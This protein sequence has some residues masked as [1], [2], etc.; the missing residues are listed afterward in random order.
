MRIFRPEKKLGCYVL[1]LL[2]SLCPTLL[3]A[4]QT[5]TGKVVDAKTKEAIIGAVIK[6]KDSTQGTVTDVNGQFKIQAGNGGILIISYVGYLSQQ[7]TIN[8]PTANVSLETDAKNLSDVV[9][10]GYGTQKRSDLTGAVASVSTE[11]LTK[12]A[13]SSAIGSMQGIVPGANIIRN[14]NKPGGGFTVDIRG[15]HSITGSNAPL[16][17]IDGVPGADL[18]KINP[19]DIEK[20]DVLKDAS[21][22][23]IYGSRGANGV[24]IV[25]TKRGQTGKPKI[26]YNGYYGVRN[27]TNKPQMMNVDEF[28]QLAREAA[29]AT[30]NNVYKPDDQVFTDPSELQ[31]VKT[32]QGFDWINAVSNPAPQTSHTLSATGGNEEIRYT[33]SGGYYYEKGMLYPQSYTR[34]NLRASLDIKATQA[35]SFGGS[36]YF[37]NEKRALGNNDLLQDMFRLRPTQFPNSLVTGA[38]AFQYSSNGLFN[39]L[40]TSQNVFNDVK[41]NNLLGNI[42]VALRPVKGLEIK[43]TFSPYFTNA[44][45]GNYT[46]VFSKALQGTAAGATASYAKANVGNWVFDN[47]INYKW[48]KDIHQLEVTGVYSLQR[49]QSDNLNAAS[50]DLT[51][52]S[53]YYNLQG[54]TMT[55]F[56]SSYT[57]SQLAS[58]LGR[59]NYTLNSKYLLTASARYDGSSKLAAGHKWVLFPSA[60]LAWRASEE[61]FLK[62][63][64]WLDNLKVRLGYGVIGNDSV[65][66]YQSTQ[67]IS[68]PTYYSFG[69]DVIGNSPGNLPNPNLSWEKTYEVNLGLDFGIFKN[70]IS[71]SIELYNR[72][73][74]DLIMPSAIPITTGYSSLAAANVGSARNKGIEFSLTTVN[75]QGK[76]LRWST[77]FS[78]AYNRNKIVDLGFK[79]DLGKYS[80][81]LAGI[82][83]D[84][85]NKWFIGQPIRSNWNLQTIGI[86]QLDQATEA[87]KYGQKPG[88]FRV[89]D[90]DNDGVINQDKD[91]FLDGKRT[92]DWTGGVYTN[93]QYK[94]FDLSAQGYFQT[95]AR[96][97]NQFYVSYQLENNNGALNNQVKD[98][99]TPENPS[100]SMGQPSNMGIYRDVNQSSNGNLI[101]VSHVVQK[102]DF[103]KVQY[104]NLGYHFPTSL[105][106][107]LKISNLRVYGTVQNP[108]TFS[109]WKGFDPEQAN[110]SI[111]STDLIT[112][113]F[114]F[115]I[116]VTF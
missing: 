109:S 58:Y 32:H 22:T 41:S 13:K 9:V 115:G 3:L 68:S 52:N 104:I 4:Q 17:V 36:M 48:S 65:D 33:L 100:N 61:K 53:L 60:A 94:S 42:Y 35:L 62:S 43:S 72:L 66:P 98:Y 75:V 107:K 64:S 111:A 93:L 86:W 116:D 5:V 7:V 28:A 87:A 39:A 105:T 18:E 11:Q 82:M 78:A 55:S 102:T 101:S 89:R 25:T 8:G 10:I 90:F 108:F 106:S 84:Y 103:F 56:G 1:F 74:K 77:T 79:E 71:G 15:V 24:F 20:I 16:V 51:F 34:Y 88:Q 21:A 37:T 54:G 76:D 112:R 59:V 81:Q 85:G 14:N 70:R 95:G 49:N 67:L 27:Y 92:P 6:V 45:T 96:D 50:R 110:V 30:N 26:S 44:A 83:G 99:W 31:A 46:G 40:V 73:T 23:A 63:I 57:Q 12:T 38:P 113:N 91:R 47:I 29:R 19:A 97:R 80:P 2:L 114:L 69:S